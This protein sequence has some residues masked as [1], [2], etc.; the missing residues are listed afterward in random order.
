MVLKAH[1][2]QST[3]LFMFKQFLLQGLRDAR[4]RRGYASLITLGGGREI[5]DIYLD[6]FK[7]N[8]NFLI[9]QLRIRKT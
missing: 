3:F 1:G 6:E 8:L 4:H 5:A 7:R 9:E 2:A